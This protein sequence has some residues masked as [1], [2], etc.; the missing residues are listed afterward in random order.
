M[1]QVLAHP[2]PLKLDCYRDANQTL[3]TCDMVVRGYQLKRLKC[4]TSGNEKTNLYN[5]T[6]RSKPL[7]RWENLFVTSS[8][9]IGISLIALVVN[10]L[11]L[12]LA[13][14]FITLLSLLCLFSGIDDPRWT[15][16]TLSLKCS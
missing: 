3:F 10:W 5:Q 13:S 6:R 16:Q 11:H 2:G 4:L 14:V 15:R 8:L 1:G 9:A 12:D 7:S